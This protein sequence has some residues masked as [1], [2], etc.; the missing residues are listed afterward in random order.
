MKAQTKDDILKL[1]KKG[2]KSEMVFRWIMSEYKSRLYWLVRRMVIQH[3]D[4]DDVLQN[5]FIKIWQNLPKFRGDSDVYTWVYRIGVNES[6]AFLQK[7]KKQSLKMNEYGAFLSDQLSADSWFDGTEAQMKLQ[8]AI[9]SL[10]DQQRLVFNM[11][12]FEEVKYK[13]MA[14]ILGK[15]EGALKANY[16]H[17]VKKIEE[18]IKG[19]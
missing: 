4:A 1:I 8:K 2:E 14:E 3:D 19:D 9:L 13:E 16:H 15:S 18:F 10:P 11:K 5:T 6:L 12:Y 17:A 7:K